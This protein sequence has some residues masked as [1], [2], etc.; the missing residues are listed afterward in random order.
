MSR[1]E[2]DH[3]NYRLNLKAQKFEDRRTKRNR[4]RTTNRYKAIQASMRGE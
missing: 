4:A 1:T 3:P 2:K